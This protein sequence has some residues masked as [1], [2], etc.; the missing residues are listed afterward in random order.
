V[1]LGGEIPTTADYRDPYVQALITA[2]GGWMLWPPVRVPL[3]H[4]QLAGVGGR[5]RCPRAT[6]AICSA[7][8]GWL[9]ICSPCCS[10]RCACRAVRLALTAVSAVI[11]IAWGPLQ[12][13]FGGRVDLVGQRLLEIWSGLPVLFL[14]IIV[15]SWSSRPSYGCC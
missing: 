3:R 2:D 7:P 5:C 10:T 13:Y 6:M 1:E 4:H 9:G 12:G 15:T 8:T 11:G 14:L